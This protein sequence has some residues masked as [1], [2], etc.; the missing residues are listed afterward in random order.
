M[1]LLFNPSFSLRRSSDSHYSAVFES[2]ALAST[3]SFLW[4]WQL[5]F[6]RYSRRVTDFSFPRV[7]SCRRLWKEISRRRAARR[8][9]R[10]RHCAAFLNTV[11]KK[12]DRYG[13]PFLSRIWCTLFQISFSL[14]RA[15][16][17]EP[18]RW[19]RALDDNSYGKRESSVVIDD[20]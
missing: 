3:S 6:S 7:F 4:H 11:R 20:T 12:K 14:I 15:E 1:V 13:G 17:E 10:L 19:D 5:D 2:S 8:L 18:L 9:H 16:R